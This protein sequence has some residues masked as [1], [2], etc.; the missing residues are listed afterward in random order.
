LLTPPPPCSSPFP[1]TPLFRSPTTFP[2]SLIARAPFVSRRR[3]Q[4]HAAAAAPMQPL[5]AA[6]ATGS[7]RGARLSHASAGLQRLGAAHDFRNFFRN[8]RLPRPVERQRQR[9]N[10]LARVVRRAAH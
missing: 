9:A 10:H 2:F 1:Y 7:R 8:G 5:C 4:L 3:P 6:A